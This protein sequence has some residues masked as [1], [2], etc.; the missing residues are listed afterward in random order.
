MQPTRWSLLVVVGLLIS[1]TFVQSQ[2]G[3][4]I[5][6][7]SFPAV[8]MLM[9]E[10]ESR[11]P[12]SLGSGFFVREGIVATCF[13]V[14]EGAVGGYAKLIGQKTKLDILGIV[15]IDERHDL[16]LL[17]VSGAKAPPLPIGDSQNVSVGDE[18][19]VVSN[20]MGLEGTFSQGIISGIRQVGSDMLFQITA[21]VSPGSSGG[22][23]LNNKG[24]VIGIAAATFRGGQNLNFA[25]PSSYLAALLSNVKPPIPLSPKAAI[26]REKSILAEF[27]GRGVE[28]VV[29]D[30]FLWKYG[31]PI[32]SFTFSLRNLLREP[33]KDI[34][35]L[36]IFYDDYGKPID[37]FLQIYCPD[38][39][40]PLD[41]LYDWDTRGRVIPGGLA[42][43][44]RGEVDG[45]VQ[46]LTTPRGSKTPQTRVE[47]RILDFR[48]V[49]GE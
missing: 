9:M 42:I 18:V 10:D 37:T 6:Q 27:G 17:A 46:E 3:K 2:T 22:P 21:P 39:S 48:I 8:V 12:L 29:G 19:Y 35:C 20:P 11:Q 15:G 30:N 36:V 40:S 41:K 13:H 7:K 16:A 47:F 34:V 33:V 1:A 4:E 43:R 26:K 25:I 24:E 44:V 5:A 38:K 14:V 45:S 31:S 23:V 32:G 49:Q 28:G